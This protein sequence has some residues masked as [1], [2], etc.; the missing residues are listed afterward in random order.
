MSIT[1][2]CVCGAPLDAH[3]RANGSR[4][5]CE[6][7]RRH[8]GYAPVNLGVLFRLALDKHTR[9]KAAA[10]ESIRQTPRGG[11]SV[12]LGGRVKGFT[13]TGK[14][15]TELHAVIT[16]YYDLKWKQRRL[17]RA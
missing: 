7:A 10:V 12:R 13:V 9:G 17:R 3:R 14:T 1:D 6:E 4:R 15:L 16:T 2:I 5:S 8:T 11:W